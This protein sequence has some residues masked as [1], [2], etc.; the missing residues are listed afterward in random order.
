MDSSIR[1]INSIGHAHVSLEKLANAM[2]TSA[3][4]LP[5]AW[6]SIVI[7]HKQEERL[8]AKAFYARQR[9]MRKQSRR[10]SR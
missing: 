1:V 6:R 8:Q 10:A 4:I 2:F 3:L 9:K 7:I 5:L